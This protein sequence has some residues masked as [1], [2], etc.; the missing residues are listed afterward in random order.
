MKNKED[1]I[2]VKAKYQPTDQWFAPADCKKIASVK[3]DGKKVKFRMV[4]AFEI[5]EYVADDSKEVE[6]LYSQKKVDKIKK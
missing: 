2:V 3:V 6:I 1:F 4:K 5:M